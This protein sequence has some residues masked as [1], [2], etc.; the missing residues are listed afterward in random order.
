MIICCYDIMID[1]NIIDLCENEKM[2]NVTQK[3]KKIKII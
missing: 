3:V 2:T 1:S